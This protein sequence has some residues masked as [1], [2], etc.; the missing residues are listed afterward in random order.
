MSVVRWTKPTK[1]LKSKRLWMW[2]ILVLCLSGI[3]FFGFLTKPYELNEIRV[4]Q[5]QPIATGQEFA[6]HKEPLADK[7]RTA[8]KNLII[9]SHGRSGSTLTG[10][11]FNHHPSVFY[12]YEPLQTPK[13]VQK[14]KN[15]NDS[16]YSNLAKEF[17]TGVFRCK[18]DNPDLLRD[19][20]RYYR[21]PEHPR[22]S[23]S[24]GS[25]PLCPHQMT[26]P[27]WNPRHCLPMTN[28]VLGSAC[29]DTYNLTV[30]KILMWRIPENSIET[31]LNACSA[32]DIDCKVIFLV[33]DPRAMVPSSR[34][35][36]FFGEQGPPNE[37]SGTRLYS[38]QRCAQ[39]E[40]NMELVRS[41]PDSFRDRIK[42]LR[43]EDLATKPLKVLADIYEFVGLPV[44]ESVRTWL[45][46]TT[47]LSRSACNWL[48]GGSVTCTKDDAWAA[49][50]R[51]RWTAHLQE[52]NVIERYCGRVLRLMGY[53]PVNGSTELLANRNIALFS[54]DYEA[55][56]WF[57][58]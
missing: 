3:Y 22:I 45:N 27:K 5:Q 52:I 42:L 26:D 24:I 43:Y 33:R 1:L 14:N 2:L 37:Y 49:A 13:R 15:M 51:W 6:E 10:D 53:R 55:K 57:L 54:D 28:E 32:P 58:H 36:G 34:K 48:D 46:K 19:I 44:L 8:R 40:A 30:L 23:K 38:Q 41:L 7:E 39:T 16:G 50:N 25:P 21:K 17:L 9:V 31:I 47:H 20:E 56:H 35:I 11:I 29:K 4:Q 18:F 12:M